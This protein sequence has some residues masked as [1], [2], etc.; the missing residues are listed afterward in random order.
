MTVSRYRNIPVISGSYHGTYNFPIEALAKVPC[1]NIR[2]TSNDRLDTLAHQHLGA[3]EYW[4]ILAML[5]NISWTFDFIP[6]ELLKIP[7]D[8]Q[9]VLRLV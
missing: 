9:D 6:G 5:N 7:Q 8:V 1:Y 4:W 3:G 2:T